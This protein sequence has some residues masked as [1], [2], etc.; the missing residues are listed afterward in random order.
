MKKSGFFVAASAAVVSSYSSSSDSKIH[1]S[2][3]VKSLVQELEKS[4]ELNI[5]NE[6]SVLMILNRVW[7][8][9]H[10]IT[11]R[12]F[13]RTKNS[14]I[15]KI[16]Y[17]YLVLMI[18][19]RVWHER[20]F[21]MVKLTNFFD[22]DYR[23]IM[24][25]VDIRMSFLAQHKHNKSRNRSRSRTARARTINSRRGSMDWGLSKL[26]SPLTDNICQLSWAF[27]LQKKKEKN[28]LIEWIIPPI[29]SYLTD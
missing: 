9:W 2:R 14:K 18:L 22:L 13:I 15:M 17:R 10:I 19:N 11:F 25:R 28:W 16:K 6:Y 21:V 3:Q 27:H 20:N 24:G 12:R 26:W 4:W 23:K 7:M 5:H 29:K 8:L 1:F